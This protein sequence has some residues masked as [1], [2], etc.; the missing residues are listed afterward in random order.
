MKRNYDARAIM[1]H[2][3]ILRH[4]EPYH[5]NKAPSRREHHYQPVMS[6]IP[7]SPLTILRLIDASLP[8]GDNDQPRLK[9]PHDALA[10]FTHACMLSVGFRL[11]G[12]NED[13]RIGTPTS[14]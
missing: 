11:I 13:D 2:P 5:L 10:A 6:N 7:F 12:L 1:S 14:L 3:R 8:Q 4:Y 9:N